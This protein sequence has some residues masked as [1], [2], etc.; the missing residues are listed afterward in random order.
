MKRR[1]SILSKLTSIKNHISTD[2]V[3]NSKRKVSQILN[4]GNKL[5]S[6]KKRTSVSQPLRQNSNSFLKILLENE[7]KGPSKEDQKS[8]IDRVVSKLSKRETFRTN[9]PRCPFRHIDRTE[10]Y[11]SVL[12]IVFKTCRFFND[13]N[14]NIKMYG[15]E[16]EINI[17]CH[18][19]ENFHTLEQIGKDLVE[20]GQELK[21]RSAF[22][23]GNLTGML[24][25]TD[26]K[27][28]II[29]TINKLYVKKDDRRYTFSSNGKFIRFIYFIGLL[30]NTYNTFI[31]P[32]RKAFVDLEFIV[33]SSFCYFELF[34]DIF[35]IFDFIF[36]FFMEKIDKNGIFIRDLPKIAKIY[37]R[38]N[39]AIDFYC[40]IPFNSILL[41]SQTNE[42]KQY[43]AYFNILRLLKIRKMSGIVNNEVSLQFFILEKFKISSNSYNLFTFLASL[44]VT[45]HLFCCCFVIFVKS[46]AM[47]PDNFLN[48]YN[49]QDEPKYYLYL[50]SFYFALSIMST[51]GYGDFVAYTNGYLLKRRNIGNNL[52]DY[53][54]RSF[55]FFDDF[56][57]DELYTT[58][59][60]GQTEFKPQT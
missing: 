58:A 27:D 26:A 25:K 42:S 11:W 33:S 56:Q 60:P 45:V 20:R 43:L 1:K 17:L 5:D 37:L 28:A 9:L 24:Q 13:I 2:F 6:S 50:S 54:R 38:S 46:Q 39:F 19:E 16:R 31:N 14:D 40:A 21:E 48:R 36:E 59:Q 52:L 22:Q 18:A 10:R 49:F 15:T 29:E 44:F 57:I 41:F 4:E 7:G 51:V 12:K 35:M 55:L 53:F 32:Y 23:E 47:D 34:I 8:E 3:A 30:V